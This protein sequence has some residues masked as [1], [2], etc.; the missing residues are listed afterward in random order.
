MSTIRRQVNIATNPR[1]VWNAL[2]TADGLA[3]WLGADARID[4]RQGGRFVLKVGG[5]DDGSP[6]EE[7]GFLHVW[8]PTAKLEVSWDK[9]SPGNWR[10]TFTQFHVAKDGSETILAVNHAG[11]AF[12]DE[13]AR[14]KVDGFWRKAL[15][16]L[17][18]QL[19]N[20]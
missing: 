7:A 19:E 2:T 9:A 6:A 20:A 18:D 8:R 16:T 14:L 4:P 5:H 11:P 10:G 15:T 1:T 12:E 13:E 3:R 17:R